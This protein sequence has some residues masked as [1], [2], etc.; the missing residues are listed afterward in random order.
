[1]RRTVA[2]GIAWGVVSAAAAAQGRPGRCQLKFVGPDPSEKLMIESVEFRGNT[3]LDEARQAEIVRKVKPEEFDDMESL[4]AE[5]DVEI[6]SDLQERGF[7]EAYD[8]VTATPVSR[9]KQDRYRV[10][11]EITAGEIFRAGAIQ[12][13]NARGKDLPL[14]VAPSTLRELFSLHEGD[15]FNASVVREGLEKM[16]REYG[17]QG[18]IDA[19]IDPEYEVNRT[20]HTIA[21]RLSIDEQVPYRIGSANALGVDSEM[22]KEIQSALKSGDVFKSQAFNAFLNEFLRKH[23]DA[24]PPE[25]SYRDVKIDRNVR[26]RTLFIQIDFRSCEQIPK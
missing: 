25:V 4:I 6:Q 7:F 22:K 24:L 10:V 15:L 11:A 9:E 21:L 12:M 1:M 23:G 3:Q 5:V 17:E 8:K 19:T 2:I 18:Y 14:G 20:N 16:T 13:V 26:G